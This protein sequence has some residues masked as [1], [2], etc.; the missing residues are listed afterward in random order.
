MA[1]EKGLFIGAVFMILGVSI[2]AFGAH[3]LKEIL[4][5]N[6]TTDTFKTGVDYLFYNSIGIFIVS[7]TGKNNKYFKY[8][9]LLLAIGILLFSFS[10]FILSLSNIKLIGIITPFGGLAFILGWICFILNQKTKN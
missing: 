4:I 5:Q 1:K 2:G 10:L 6:G 8:S 7:I 3:S 9:I